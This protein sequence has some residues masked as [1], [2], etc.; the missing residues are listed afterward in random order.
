MH[1]VRRKRGTQNHEENRVSTSQKRKKKH[2]RERPRP[3]KSSTM[4]YIPRAKGKWRKGKNGK[5]IGKRPDCRLE[6]PKPEKASTGS[7]SMRQKTKKGTRDNLSATHP[8]KPEVKK[9][10]KSELRVKSARK[11]RGR[12]D[13]GPDRSRPRRRKKWKER[14]PLSVS[15]APGG[16]VLSPEENSSPANPC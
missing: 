5:T 3:A 4:S 11:K 16:P 10:G 1:C 6:D 2:N 13:L 12:T 9:V 15:P 8:T 14:R 7:L